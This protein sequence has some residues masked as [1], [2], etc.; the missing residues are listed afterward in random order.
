M[1][2][3]FSSPRQVLLACLAVVA[4]A[5]LA[6]LTLAP[7]GAE[8]QGQTAITAKGKKPCKRHKKPGGSGCGH[9]CGRRHRPCVRPPCPRDGSS[10]LVTRCRPVV[11]GL[12]RR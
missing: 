5:A 10:T 4:I 6:A 12:A 2:S 1:T 9:P 8:A 11:K 3:T 7:A